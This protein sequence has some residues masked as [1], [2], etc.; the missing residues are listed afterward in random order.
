MVHLTITGNDLS[1]VVTAKI[2]AQVEVK[3]TIT[4]PARRADELIHTIV[5]GVLEISA[6]SE[7]VGDSG[8]F[9]RITSS[10]STSHF[11]YDDPEDYPLMPTVETADVSATV[12]PATLFD[13]IRRVLPTVAVGGFKTGSCQ[14]ED[15]DIR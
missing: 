6:E 4:L 15:G 5:D 13:G 3:E 2:S 14:H 1:T 10:R 12:S 11:D 7:D 9:A 8:R